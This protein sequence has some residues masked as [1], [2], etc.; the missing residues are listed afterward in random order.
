MKRLWKYFRGYGKE[1]ILGPLFKLLEASFEL[2]IPL[3]VKHIIDAGIPSKD[4]GSVL[5][6]V[7]LMVLLGV[8]GMVCSIT[9]Q[10]FSA[11]AAVGFAAGVKH[12]VFSHIRHLSYTEI[13]GL[14]TSTM[15]TRMTSDINTLQGGVN[16]SLRLFLRSPFIVFGAVVMAF[17]IDTKTAL[18]FVATVAALSVVVYGIMLIT[19]PMHKKVQG[20]LDRILS[21]TR[22]NLIGVRVIRAFGQEEKEKKDFKEANDG[23][24]KL[25]LLSGR[26]SALLNPVTFV[27]INAGTIWVI[28]SGSL[29]VDTGRLTQGSVVALINYMA[30][31]LVELIKLA[32]MIVQLT[33]ALACAGRISSVLETESS[34]R[35]GEKT[36][37][38]NGGA[39]AISLND[40]SMTYA[41]G[42]APAVEGVTLQITPGS[43]VGIIGGTG[44]G[45]TSLVQLIPRFYDAGKGTVLVDGTDVREYT[46]DSLR[47]R[48]A[49]VPQKAVLF[50]GTIRS[51]LRMGKKDATD[52]EMKEA[53]RCA[54]ALSFVEEKEGLDTAVAQGGKNFSGGQRQRL[55]IARALV[56]HPGILILDDSASALDYATDAALRKSIRELP[57]APTTIIV[58]QR[59]AS[60]LHADRILVLDGGAVAGLG[61]HEELLRDCEVY[62]EIYES[63]FKQ[64]DA[65]A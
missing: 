6:L 27:L 23:L 53:L 65:H 55:T 9:A 29:A 13:D 61:T 20:K 4:H 49:V 51:N 24:V 25:Q 12:A 39:C 30:Q 32:N 1:C 2:M 38:W 52:E 57:D 14:G 10:F 31:I 8:V 15:I 22:S 18:C 28:R 41:G 58:S 63:Q 11:K 36:V 3:V 47:S 62:R 16:M 44:S 42:S 48:I 34:M 60:I 19:I 35:E 56:R 50:A 33:R 37:E 40:V 43:T 7:G 64:E 54:Q 21:M 17:T 5:L 59:A 26:I 45:K 46:Y